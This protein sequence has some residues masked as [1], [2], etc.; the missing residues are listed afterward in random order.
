MGWTVPRAAAAGVVAWLALT[1]CDSADDGASCAVLP[2]LGGS[3]DAGAL[4]LL[5]AQA[6]AIVGVRTDSQ[7]PPLCTATLIAKDLWITGADCVDESGVEI[8]L[9]IAGRDPT[10]RRADVRRLERHR[11]YPV[12]A[13]QLDPDAD[14]LA[15]MEIAPIPFY[16][17]EIEDTWPGPSVSIASI[18][19]T[20][21]ELGHP[22]FVEADVADVTAN[23]LRVEGGDESS[24][25]SGDAGAPML[26]RDSAGD[27]R[28]VGV[29]GEVS[30]D[31]LGPDV[32]TRADRLR[33]WLA[34]YLSDDEED[35]LGGDES[36]APVRR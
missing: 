18:G 5:P 32:Y 11:D 1:G 30:T 15:S 4:S 20:K 3:A 19:T 28:V 34:Q 8:Q 24:A 7:G 23:E 27:L 16:T 35:L 10:W 22:I 26:A 33:D 9:A 29:L 21:Q 14:W 12:A 31:C 2:L 13:F 17:D 6:R 25:C 36:C